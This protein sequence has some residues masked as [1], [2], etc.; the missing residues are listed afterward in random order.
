ME[1]IAA[2]QAA[3]GASGE[4]FAGMAAVYRRLAATDLAALP[5]EQAADLTDLT[6]VLRRLSA[7]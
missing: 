1:Q 6:A 4:L 7:D 5:P 3:A 2:T